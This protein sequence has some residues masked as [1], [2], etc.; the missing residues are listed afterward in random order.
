L[1]PGAIDLATP[2]VPTGAVDIY[3]SVTGEWSSA[4]L[5]QGR[6]QLAATTVG[7]KA[8]FAG[9]TGAGGNS[10]LVDIYDTVTNEW[11]TATLSHPRWTTAA[12]TGTKAIFAGGYTLPPTVD[13]EAEDV[14]D[15]YD[16]T[17]GQWSTTRLPVSGAFQLAV[18][19]GSRALF[20]GGLLP[21]G[22]LPQ[23]VELYDG[24]TGQWSEHTLSQPRWPLVATTV[25][26]RVLFAGA[27]LGPAGEPGLVDIYDSVTG[28]WETT[29]M[30]VARG[31]MVAT[32]VANLAIFAGGAT[33]R[34]D[35]PPTTIDYSIPSDAVDIYDAVAG[36]WGSATLPQP[37]AYTVAAAVGTKALFAGGT[38]DR[39]LS[40]VV[41]IYD[42]A[43]RR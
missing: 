5:A 3:D 32:A 23:R 41:D 6:Y 25:G 9:G 1:P 21:G 17:T 34:R 16:D 38:V 24:V 15:I 27:P 4:L 26:T 29:E 8:F 42:V 2:G 13:P 14:T 39:R 18:S 22:A 20:A 7:R 10:D 43:L 19:V 31:R 40:N 12:S 36:Q 35:T 30:S 33:R 28:R 37:R 11:S